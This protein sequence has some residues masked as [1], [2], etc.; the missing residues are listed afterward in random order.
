MIVALV[1]KA[2]SDK[3]AEEVVEFLESKGVQVKK[4]EIPEE[5]LE[6]FDFIV[7]IGGDGTILGILQKVTR[8]P[9][10]FGIN[11]GRIGLLNHT[12]PEYFRESLE[13]VIRGELKTEEFMRIEGIADDRKIT[14]INEIAVLSSIPAKLV[15]ISVK[16]DGVMIEALRGDGMVFSTP[17]GSTAYALS[18]G[19]PVID[20]YIQSILIVPIAPFKIGWKP[21][22]VG[23]DRQI[24]TSIY[25]GKALVVADGQETFDLKLGETLIIKKSKYPAVFFKSSLERIEKIVNKIKKIG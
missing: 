20:P 3:I 19:G 22:V 10:I 14:A 21:W 9:P 11:T 6:D 24:E 16:V 23:E 8:C 18:S 4:Y 13:K 7:S 17:I 15:G 2:G 5:G 12:E 25:S 1:Y